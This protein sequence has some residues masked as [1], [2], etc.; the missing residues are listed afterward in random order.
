[1]P[2]RNATARFRFAW[3]RQSSS[4]HHNKGLIML[5]SAALAIALLFVSTAAW[6]QVGPHNAQ[7]GDACFRDAHRF[8]RDAIPDQ[9]RVLSC[10][11]QNRQRLSKGCNGV[12]QSHGV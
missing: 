10:L 11:Q 8:C 4:L 6:T 9:L 7:E 1:M 5:R 2:N 3:N 12:L